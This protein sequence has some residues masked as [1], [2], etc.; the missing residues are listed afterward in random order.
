MSRA[1]IYNEVRF[2]PPR[3]Q[4]TPLRGQFLGSFKGA[5]N[6][7][8]IKGNQALTI[9]KMCFGNFGK[10]QKNDSPGPKLMHREPAVLSQS[11]KQ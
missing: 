7:G 11:S 5:K 6:H 9:T 1:Y 4:R 10:R 8:K 3:C 2:W